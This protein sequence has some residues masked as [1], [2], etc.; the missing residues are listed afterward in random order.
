MN[1]YY[2]MIVSKNINSLEEL[3]NCD[4]SVSFFCLFIFL[5]KCFI[6]TQNT[7]KRIDDFKIGES[8]TKLL[9]SAIQTFNN[10]VKANKKSKPNEGMSFLNDSF[11]EI[12]KYQIKIDVPSKK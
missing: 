3:L 4:H 9:W 1:A 7:F 10:N 5:I 2:N 6:E 11:F 12:S 8:D